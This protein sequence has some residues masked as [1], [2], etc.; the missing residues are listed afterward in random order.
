MLAGQKRLAASSPAVSSHWLGLPRKG[1][2]TAPKTRPPPKGLTAG[3]L[4]TASSF[5]KG[6]SGATS[7]R[8]PFL[9]PEFLAYFKGSCGGKRAGTPLSS[10]LASGE[11]SSLWSGFLPL[12]RMLAGLQNPVLLPPLLRAPSTRVCVLRS[13]SL[14]RCVRWGAGERTE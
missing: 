4:C 12:V 7:A 9:V 11:A 5:W 1:T 10:L 13:K 6:E 2:T 8:P 14:F 3:E